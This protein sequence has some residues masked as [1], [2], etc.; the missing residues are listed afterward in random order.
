MLVARA[1]G[2]GVLNE[3]LQATDNR[4]VRVRALACASAFVLQHARDVWQGVQLRAS[5]CGAPSG[6]RHPPPA[7][8]AATAAEQILFERPHNPSGQG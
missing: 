8:V 4:W 5:C 2:A 3:V 7:V 6:P 1:V